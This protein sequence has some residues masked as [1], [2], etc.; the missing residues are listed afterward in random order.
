MHKA[1]AKTRGSSQVL[2]QRMVNILKF[3][4]A[5]LLAIALVLSLFGVVHGYSA[6][7][8]GVIYLVPAIYLSMR[9]L[10]AKR[11]ALV[12]V[13]AGRALADLYIGQIWKMVIAAMLFSAVFVLVKPLSPFSLFGT[14]IAMQ[15]SGWLLQMKAE[16]SFKKL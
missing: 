2:R 1:G 14:Y 9:T 8:G 16:N 12:N 15:V 11:S 10:S 7:F 5:I 4:A 6:L 3:Q 13:S